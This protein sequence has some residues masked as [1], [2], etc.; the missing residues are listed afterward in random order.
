MR[1]EAILFD[2]GGTLLHPEWE[3][4]AALVG[5]PGAG[6]RLLSA[7]VEAKRQLSRQARQGHHADW[8]TLLRAVLEGAG[9]A[10]DD[11]TLDLLWGAHLRQNFWRRPD[12]EAA[13]VLEALRAAGVP[14][15]V[16]SNSEGKVRE[17]L[18]ETGLAG[19]FRVILDSGL[20][21]VAKPAPALFWRGCARMGVAP[22]AA[23]YVGDVFAI[24]IVGATG[25]GMHAALLDPEGV[26]AEQ[27]PPGGRSIAGLRALLSLTQDAG[28][29]DSSREK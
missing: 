20:E 24:D 14:L 12:P 22:G 25:A 17:L 13:P 19:Y 29:T 4:V 27:H 23:L 15:G 6:S 7:E 28:E 9:L 5:A 21:G 3:R 18:E 8:R 2:V 11:T 1:Y 26:Y 10:G 16:I